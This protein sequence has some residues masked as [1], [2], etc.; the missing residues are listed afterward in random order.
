MANTTKMSTTTVTPSEAE[1]EA[2]VTQALATQPETETG[3]SRP[4]KVAA[5]VGAVGATGLAAYGVY[6]LGQH[7]GWWGK[8]TG[9][10]VIDDETTPADGG[11]T[12]PIDGGSTKKIRARGKP[13]NMSGDPAGYNTEQ[14][15]GPGPM[16]LA[17]LSQGY[18]VP[19]QRTADQPRRHAQRLR[20]PVPGRLEQGDPRARSRAGQVP[21]GRD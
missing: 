2:E 10:I 13:P 12:A 3:L 20:D 18:K 16:R 17:L 14:F 19:R 5:G 1:T 8:D 15:P 6:R 11:G 4:Q 7:F 9:G 21:L